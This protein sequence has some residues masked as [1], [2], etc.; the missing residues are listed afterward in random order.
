M[1]EDKIDKIIEEHRTDKSELIPILQDVQA[2]YNWLPQDTLR[3]IA[4]RLQ[5]PL[6]DVFGIATFYKSFSLKP[7]GKHL[8]RV[9]LGTACHVRGGPRILETAERILGIKTGETTE[10]YK[11]TLESVNCLGCCALGPVMV[12]DN[13][14]Y[15]KLP[16]TKVEKVLHKYG[17]TSLSSG[18]GGET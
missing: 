4:K 13:E 7:R 1:D 9:C 16:P 11:F 17:Y 2:E 14:Y 15:G 10:D 12:V 18:K 8:V 6:T 3:Y 5:V